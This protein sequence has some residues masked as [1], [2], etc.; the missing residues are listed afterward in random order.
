MRTELRDH[1]MGLVS[2]EYH[3]GDCSSEVDVR[4]LDTVGFSMV[5]ALWPGDRVELVLPD[6]VSTGD[7]VAFV[8][9]GGQ[10]LAHRVVG[11]CSR[12]GD[13]LIAGDANRGPDA[14]VP[15][16]AIIGVVV[17]VRRRFFGRWHTVPQGLW[18]GRLPWRPARRSIRWVAFHWKAR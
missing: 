5:P 12:S 2:G 17:R 16:K 3:R 6:V 14:P 9:E 8:G 7:V 13:Y 11:R 18:R 1:E 15:R 10:R 4:R